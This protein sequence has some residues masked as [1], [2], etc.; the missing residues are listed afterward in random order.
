M[1]LIYDSE[2]GG[3][4]LE[5]IHHLWEAIVH[6]DSKKKYII[7]V[8]ESQWMQK[9]SLKEWTDCDRIA[10]R[11][12]KDDEIGMTFRFPFQKR[13]RKEATLIRRL[14]TENK[15]ITRVIMLNLAPSLPILPF[16]VRSGI[17]VSG[18][19]YSLDYYAHFSGLRMVKERLNLSQMAK[20]HVFENIFLLNAPKAVD[21]YN[22]IYNT[23]HF[24]LLVDPVPEVDFHRIQNVRSE[25]EIDKQATVFLHFGAMQARKGTL[26]L[27]EALLQLEP[28]VKRHFIFAGKVSGEIKSDFYRLA[29]QAMSKGHRIHIKDEFI[30]FDELYNLCYSTDCLLAPYTDTDC[31]SG[32]IGYGAVFGK[33]VIG[34]RDGLLG[35]LIELNR[36]GI[37]ISVSATS[38]ANELRNFKKQTIDSGYKNTNTVKTF[39]E[40]ILS[41]P[42]NDIKD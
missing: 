36:L 34:S 6:S 33:P 15:N 21:Y 23:D 12:L 24:K 19:I 29:E 26:V 42:R 25:F 2:L 35:E 39:T 7:A 4:H 27:L 40:T 30:D 14:I 8:P 1:I 20:S 3:H 10:F 17:K 31:S 13:A 22:K 38:L 9:V 28:D 18:I 11:L 41:N 37:T 32:V 16:Y 5:Y